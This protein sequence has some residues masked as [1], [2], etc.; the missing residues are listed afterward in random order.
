MLGTEKIAAFRI[1]PR[2][3]C[4]SRKSNGREWSRVYIRRLILSTAFAWVGRCQPVI[5]ALFASLEGRR[6]GAVIQLS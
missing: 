5:F 2:L 1:S 6:F 4:G 3:V